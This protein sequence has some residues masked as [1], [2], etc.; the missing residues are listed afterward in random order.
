MNDKKIILD[1][2]VRDKGVMVR[3]FLDIFAFI[4][5]SLGKAAWWLKSQH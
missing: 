1:V 3:K 2:G 5:S 4:L